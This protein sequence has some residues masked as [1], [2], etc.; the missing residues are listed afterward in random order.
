MIYTAALS[1][2]GIGGILG[3]ILAYASH[4]LHV[5]ADPRVAEITDVLPG[6]NCGSCGY[7]GCAGYAEAIVNNSAPLNACVPGKAETARRIAGIMGE[8]PDSVQ[9]E[10]TITRLSAKAGG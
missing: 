4:K 5:K 9:T 6:A 3:L 8:S 2:A 7:P 10:R 1:L